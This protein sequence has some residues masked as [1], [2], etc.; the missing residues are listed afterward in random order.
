MSM[1]EEIGLITVYHS[2]GS[3]QRMRR[4]ADAAV[5][6]CR[7][8]DTNPT[9][10]TSRRTFLRLMKA[11]TLRGDCPAKSFAPPTPPD[12][13]RLPPAEMFP[14]RNILRRCV[15]IPDRAPPAKSIVCPPGTAKP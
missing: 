11:C 5:P 7:P 15:A 1:H 14:R 10:K 8:G 12:G 13:T 9:Q 6:A 4:F 2:R 3:A